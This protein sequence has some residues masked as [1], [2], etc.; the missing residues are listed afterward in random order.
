[1][2]SVATNLA[3]EGY[4]IT[5]IEGQDTVDGSNV[6][7]VG[8]RVKGDTLARPFLVVSSAAN[9]NQITA[10]GYAVVGV[11]NNTDASGD[12]LFKNFLGER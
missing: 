1:V 11:V 2:T 6:L 10:Q 7:V 3:S 8:T 4:I 5:A 9:L 12:L